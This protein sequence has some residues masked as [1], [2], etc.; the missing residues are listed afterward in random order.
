MSGVKNF[1]EVIAR[2]EASTVDSIRH[3]LDELDVSIGNK[4]L[5]LEDD[6]WPM[7]SKAVNKKV[8]KF[9]KEKG[10]C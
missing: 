7:L 3:V 1:Q 6:E 4:L 10:I 2:V 5:A 9:N 8:A